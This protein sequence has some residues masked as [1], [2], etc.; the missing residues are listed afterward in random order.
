MLLAD[1][2]DRPSRETQGGSLPKIK[3]K[4][5]QNEVQK[6]AARESQNEGQ[7]GKDRIPQHVR[8]PR[9]HTLAVRNIMAA[10]KTALV[11]HQPPKIA[12]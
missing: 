9:S 6:E 2:A 1:G 3:R 11:Q 8:I 4:E 5:Q 10:Q 12:V 7:R